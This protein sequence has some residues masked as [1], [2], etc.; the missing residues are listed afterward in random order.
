MIKD[1]VVHLAQILV[2]SVL[3][4]IVV[5]DVVVNYGM[6]LSRSWV[7][8]LGGSLQIDMTYAT[9]PVFGGEPRRL[10]K[11]TKLAYIVSDP[12]HPNN[13]LVYSKDRDLGC[14]IL[15]VNNE[16]RLHTKI[17]NT[18]LCEKKDFEYGMWK[19]Y[20]DGA[21]S[22]ES[23]RAG[24]LL[25]LPSGKFFPFSFRL[26]FETNSTNNVCEYEA[27]VLGL[28]ATGK[29]KITKL[30]I[31]G[32]AKLIFKQIR[33]DFQAKHPR[34]RSY[35]NFAWDLIENLFLAFN[36]H[37]IPRHKNQYNDSLAVVASTFK[38]PKVPNLK[39]EV[40]MK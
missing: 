6:L 15:P 28:V 11:E 1:L 4:D 13:N 5:A 2:K 35:K 3:M 23:V 32:D 29:M 38:P 27:L 8:K 9:I 14:F 22:W 10:Y 34:M 19:M 37:A 33:K 36:I 31:Y 30:T 40:E 20:F 21:S 7:S 39:Y 24:I 17:V 25:I 18:P 16:Q 26:Q 12:N